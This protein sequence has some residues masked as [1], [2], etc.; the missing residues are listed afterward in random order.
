MKVI[1]FI[2]GV[3]L[4][5]FSAQTVGDDCTPLEC[6]EKA[7]GLVQSFDSRID[8]VQAQ[9]SQLAKEN[10]ALKAEVADLKKRGNNTI[11]LQDFSCRIVSSGHPS[12]ATCTSGEIATGGGCNC[13]DNVYLQSGG[14][15]VS[16]GYKC[17][18]YCTHGDWNWK[19]PATAYA[20]C[21]KVK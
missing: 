6:Y 15:P 9:A 11:G 8:A 10:M 5:A 7:I 2:C 14:I 12:P 1:Q 19:E 13:N 20:V 17:N 18:N 21:C 4:I 3:L 16:N